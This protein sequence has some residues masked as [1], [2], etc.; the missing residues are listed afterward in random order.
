MP[1]P[2]ATAPPVRF[3]ELPANVF[4]CLECGGHLA[5]GG[6]ILR[7]GVCHAEYP[8]ALGVP[9]LVKGCK[10]VANSTAIPP[11]TLIALT[12]V[13][14]IAAD[15]DA[16]TFFER[17]LS[18]GYRFADSALDSENN[19]LLNRVGIRPPVLRCAALA[20]ANFPPHWQL[21][22]HY[23]PGEL[24]ADVATSF[25]VRIRNTG[26]GPWVGDWKSGKGFELIVRWSNTGTLEKGAPIPISLPPGDEVTVPIFFK[27]P[28]RAGPFR[29][30]IALRA[31]PAGPPIDP[32]ELPVTIRGEAWFPLQYVKR[33][34]FSPLALRPVRG[35]LIEGYNEDHMEAIRIL[36]DEVKR[37]GS[38]NGL[39]VGGCSSPMTAN[40][41]CEI[42]TTDIDV[43]TL[44]A[45]RYT[46]ARRNVHNCTFV[47][48]D[49][50]ALPFQRRA[51]DFVAIFA[52]LHHFSD[53]AAVLK[54]VA[55]LIRP[56][57]FVAVMCEPV[58]HYEGQPDDECLGQM[59][60]GVN[61][62]RFSLEEYDR[63][64]YAAGLEPV[65]AQVDADSLKSIWKLRGVS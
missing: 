2:S 34:W 52:A 57:G 50:H 26:D 7:C 37:R 31:S 5:N 9:L 12:K 61:E 8:V 51:F 1:V 21:V 35:P 58:G 33:K 23:I 24:D 46:F 28:K 32:V 47:C 44:Q 19:L 65:S 25:N 11:E 54:K 36:H 56:S 29:L 53:P 45:G 48:C 30:S 14:Q 49:S 38:R 4:A 20:D 15:G 42:V 16:L 17:V 6:Q 41:P 59:T 22:R 63:M 40:L 60:L 64:F 39:E 18:N 55:T 3:P 13:Y 27:T 62:Q 10:A 43:Q